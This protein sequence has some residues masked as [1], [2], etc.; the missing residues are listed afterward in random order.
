MLRRAAFI[1]LALV[2]LASCQSSRFFIPGQ[3]QVVLGNIFLEYYNIAEEYEKIPNYTKAAEYY[4]KAA[5]NKEIRKASYF[6]A[7]R[8]YALA[9]EWEKA[10]E[11]YLELQKRDKENVSIKESL[12]YIYAMNNDFEKAERFYL[13]LLTGNPDLPHLQVNYTIVLLTLEKY[14]DAQKQ[15]EILKEKFPDEE[16]IPAIEEKIT[17]A[18][19]PPTDESEGQIPSELQQPELDQPDLEDSEESEPK[20]KGEESKKTESSKK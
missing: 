12:A 2:L 7:A 6:K 19:N 11:V 15:L 14:E 1:A 16:K 20:D 4:I 17:A 5:S 13:E 8:S 9:K 3:K 10:L 18:L